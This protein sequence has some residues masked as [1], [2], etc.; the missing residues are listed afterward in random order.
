M[1]LDT[2]TSLR[3][4]RDF[5]TQAD[6]PRLPGV[7]DA[8]PELPEAIRA[9]RARPP[10]GDLLDDSELDAGNVRLFVASDRLRSRDPSIPRDRRLRLVRGLGSLTLLVVE[11]ARDV[12]P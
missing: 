9:G 12:G 2:V 10:S 6:D 7:V 8:W 4:N 1:N 3:G 11:I 5:P